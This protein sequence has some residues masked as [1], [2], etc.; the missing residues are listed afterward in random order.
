LNLTYHKWIGEN[1]NIYLYT[2]AESPSESLNYEEFHYYDNYDESEKVIIDII[3]LSKTVRI[4]EIVSLSEKDVLRAGRLRS[5]LGIK[6]I[7][8]EQAW[9]FRDKVAMKDALYAANIQIPRYNPINHVGDIL[10]FAEKEEFNVVIKPRRGAGSRGVDLFSNKGELM[11]YLENSREISPNHGAQ[12]MIES[13]IIGE[14]YHVD[15]I[16]HNNKINNSF[17]SKYLTSCLGYKN[18]KPLA[19]TLVNDS[20]KFKEEVSLITEK[21]LRVL[22]KDVTCIFHAEVFV[23]INGKVFINEI[24]CRIGGAKIYQTINTVCNYNIIEQYLKIL[25][26]DE[27]KIDKS[28]GYKLGGWVLVPPVPGTIKEVA[29]IPPLDWIVELEIKCEVNQVFSSA[30]SAMDRIFSAIVNGQTA[31]EVEKRLE[32]ITELFYDNTVLSE[33]N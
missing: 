6:G 27:V 9:S 18:N 26:S 11:N 12:L 32:Y 7:S 17:V 16:F 4:D 29:Q 23:D 14:L 25:T 10:S 31:E 1:C 24:A 2:N 3:E 13:K 20:D 22:S 21:S 19:S 8:G 15:G 33:V 28:L 30:T 5:Y